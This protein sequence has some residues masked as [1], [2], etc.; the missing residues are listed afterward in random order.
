MT[1]TEISDLITDK[2]GRQDTQSTTICKSFLKRRYKMIWDSTLWLESL[3]VCE[4][5]VSSG[6][7]EVTISSDPSVFYSP[8]ATTVA[9]T[10]P[11]VELPV[12]I[13]FEKTG[14][15]SGIEITPSNWWSHFQID[16]QKLI[17]DSDSQGT[18][19]NFIHIAKSA[20]G[21][22]R[23]KLVPSPDT[24]GTVMV[25]GKLAWAE[26]EDSDSP[27]IHGIDNILLAYGEGDMLERGRKYAKA[28]VK[29]QEAGA[30]LSAAREAQRNQFASE[31]VIIPVAFENSR[32]ILDF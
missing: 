18:P 8:K 30:L 23:I 21:Y 2:L 11:R 25:M 7:P 3:G 16:P 32:T 5:S 13:R 14:E 10:A 28:Q 29:F 20:T 22:S 15:S 17:N 4:E 24:A 31:T 26:P 6:T 1:I 27:I 12:A 19:E 9:S